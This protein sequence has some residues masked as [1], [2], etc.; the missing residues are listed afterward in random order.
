MVYAAAEK[1]LR[2]WKD[3]HTFGPICILL[4]STP[5]PEKFLNK[6]SNSPLNEKFNKEG[7]LSGKVHMA[8]HPRS[9]DKSSAMI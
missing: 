2:V 9:K 1:G 8:M 7:E 3:A 5:P 4:H 6:N